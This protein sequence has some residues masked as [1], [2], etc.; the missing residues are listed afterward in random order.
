MLSNT[1][2]QEMKFVFLNICM[3]YFL[4]N[5]VSPLCN[6]M[7]QPYLWS[8]TTELHKGD[9]KFHKV[10]LV[11]LGT[12]FSKNKEKEYKQLSSYSFQ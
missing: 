12:R 1:T 8:Y 6:S 4:K 11:W 9:T 7:V 2:D 5:F 3:P 10:L